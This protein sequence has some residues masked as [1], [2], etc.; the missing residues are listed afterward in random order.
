MYDF[1]KNKTVANLDNVPDNIKPFY[2]KEDPEAE[3]SQFVLKQNDPVVASAVGIITSQQEI[4]HKERKAKGSA[5]DLTPLASYG[6]TVEEIVAGVEK[7][8]TGLESQIKDGGASVA[9][10]IE[11]MKREMHTAH[12][13]VVLE[14]DK[15]I[16]S[17]TGQL[18]EHMLNTAIASAA[19]SF[20]KLEPEL[21]APFARQRMKVEVADDGKRR[22]VVLDAGGEVKFSMDRPGEKASATELLEEMSKNNKFQQLFPAK[23]KQGSN[24]QANNRNTSNHDKGGPKTAPEKIAAGVGKV[25][26]QRGGQS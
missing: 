21:I 20:D 7:Q 9:K 6:N 12:G 11:D 18:D 3:D 24:I 13:A 14:K 1:G 23:N 4:V 16:N 25:L 22:V 5:V 19:Q 15:E 26:A 8:K 17:L 2:E 10:Q